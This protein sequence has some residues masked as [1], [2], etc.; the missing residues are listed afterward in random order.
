MEIS[1]LGDFIRWKRTMNAMSQQQVTN[2]ARR[3]VPGVI[4]FHRAAVAHWEMNTRIPNH[5]QTR[6]LCDALDL[7][8]IE[9]G[10]LVELIIEAELATVY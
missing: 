8:E 1:N 3:S 9:K 10:Q 7:S 2:R 4:G 6:A 5:S